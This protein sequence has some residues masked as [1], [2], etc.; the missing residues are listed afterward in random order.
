MRQ[1]YASNAVP[2]E[3]Q[4][5]GTGSLQQQ[6]APVPEVS[7]ALTAGEDFPLQLPSD[8]MYN[9]VNAGLRSQQEQDGSA[10][11]PVEG[12]AQHTGGFQSLIA[13]ADA[14]TQE[15]GYVDSV[16]L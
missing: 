7:A 5:P 12:S 10:Q 8:Q 16:K 4:P 15:P 13:G 11:E 1:M 6:S 2:A 3:L 14:E 9:L